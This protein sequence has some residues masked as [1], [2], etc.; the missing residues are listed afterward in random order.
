MKNPLNKRIKRE[1]LANFLRY[2]SI[3]VIIFGSVAIS[4]GFFVVQKSVLSVY[5][6]SLKN[7]IAEDGQ[8]TLA[9]PL[10]EPGK[11]VFA[12]NTK[13]YA[14]NFS[15]DVQYKT[16]KSLRV[17][18]NRSKINLPA[19]FEGR[20]PI[21]ADEIALN[22]NFI[23][24]N[25]LKIGDYLVLRNEKYRLVGS[26][27]LPDHSTLL[28]ERG[29]MMMNNLNFGVAVMTSEG[30]DKLGEKALSYTYSYILSEKL[31][32]KE[33]LKR[34]TEI[35]EKLLK[36]GNVV[37]DGV[38]RQLNS[39]ISYFKD[40]MGGDVPM[41]YVL[42]V[43]ILFVMAFLF[44]VIVKSTIEDEAPV[45]GALMSQGYS[46]KRLLHYY[47]RL[48]VLVTLTAEVL[49]SLVGYTFVK[50][51][52]LRVYY[53]NYGLFPF[54][55]E[56]DLAALIVTSL[57]PITL[58][59]AVN[60]VLIRRKLSFSPLQFLRRDIK[61]YG[62]KTAAKLP[63][64]SFIS[65]F[66]LRIFLNNKALYLLMFI[67]LI[68][69][70]L[71]LLFSFATM[72][73]LE[74]YAN[75]LGATLPAKYEYHL[76]DSLKENVSENADKFTFYTAQ[77]KANNSGKNLSVHLFAYD[78]DNHFFPNYPVTRG[79][80]RV[81]ASAGLLK[82]MNLNVGDE[83][84]LQDLYYGRSY[85]FKI[86]GESNYA[87]NLG[88]Y[89]NRQTLN[90]L[91]DKPQDYYNGLFSNEPLSFEENMLLT[92][93]NADKLKEVGEQMTLF[94]RGMVP[95][96]LVVSLSIFLVVILVLSQIVYKRSLMS[97]G[98]LRILGYRKKEIGKIYIGLT[99]LI[100]LIFEIISVPLVAVLMKKSFVLS[101]S[102]LN[103][104]IE[105]VVPLLYY[106]LP[107][108]LGFALYLVSKY[109][110]LSKIEKPDLSAALKEI[111]G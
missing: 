93:V 104:Y 69:A 110:Q 65:R 96:L 14:E 57:I 41:M 58:V 77:A 30:F 98:Y 38:I 94:F 79:S 66:R 74:N 54:K 9:Y 99:E 62:K 40:D 31:S 32:E 67:G 4:A 73:I 78:E 39:G 68:L 25:D 28:K 50:D 97:I 11:D 43:L 45:I 64:Y 95:I 18:I 61:K 60:Y 19:F 82:K 17:Y 106:F 87:A 27:A 8:I 20:A 52:F 3:F 24:H 55:T 91:I 83:I 70:N 33:S 1:L 21:S 56:I 103:G 102:K 12:Q 75:T 86:A 53:K 63:D 111:N 101:M 48:P 15:K 71:L 109:I 49:G 47:L 51:F 23:E 85:K 90:R 84:K 105:P 92:T 89:L 46:R 44:V 108:I 107:A 16:D 22:R 88:L 34:F 13:L 10:N 81:Y 76:R 7:G 37:T 5:N 6:N 100:L 80:L 2:F 26:L 29:D 59:L 35:T 72:P 36:S 42:L